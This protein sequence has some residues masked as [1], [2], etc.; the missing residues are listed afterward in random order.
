[1]NVGIGINTPTSAL[2]VSRTATSLPANGLGL[3][4]WS[5]SSAATFVGD[6]FRIDTGSNAT[7]TGNI[8]S[9][10]NN[11]SN[12]FS[13]SQSKIT[14]ALPHEFTAA[15]DVSFGNDI[16]LTNSTVAY[17]KSSSASL[18]LEAG[19]SYASNDITLSTF[20]SGNVVIDS[21]ALNIGG[22]VTRG[23]LTVDNTY[24]PLTGKALASFNQV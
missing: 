22:G 18:N 7:I 8:L 23:L 1:G 14:S 3:F 19:P 5:P 20:N 13:V 9:I 15:G 12:L 6:L 21:R 16:I 17:I 11:G 24:R 10:R 2:H 4:N